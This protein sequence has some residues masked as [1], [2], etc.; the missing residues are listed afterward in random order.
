MNEETL[1]HIF[2]PFYSTRASGS[3]L[4]MTITRQLVEQMNGRIEVFSQ[5]NEGTTVIIQF[6]L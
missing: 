1:S 2:D 4:G 3:G 6:P 5:L